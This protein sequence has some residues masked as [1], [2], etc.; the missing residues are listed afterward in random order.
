MTC[1]AAKAA[2]A[3]AR[4]PARS[5][6][7]SLARSLAHAPP[8]RVAARRSLAGGAGVSARWRSRGEWV[9][10]VGGGCWHAMVPPPPG[11]GEDLPRADDAAGPSG[12]GS[13][14]GDGGGGGSGGER[15]RGAGGD[16]QAMDVFGGDLQSVGALMVLLI[17]GLMKAAASRCTC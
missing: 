13:G 2:G 3:P 14:S 11:K 16:A 7:R 5:P 12:S 6:A 17:L 1:V 8:L 9:R 15:G 4:P 10:V